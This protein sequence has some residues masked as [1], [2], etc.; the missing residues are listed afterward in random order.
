MR[1][2]KKSINF[3]KNETKSKMEHPTQFQRAKPCV[4]AHIKIAN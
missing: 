3:N 2:V 1:F 4:S